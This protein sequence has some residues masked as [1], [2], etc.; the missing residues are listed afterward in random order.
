MLAKTQAL[1]L[2]LMI[3]GNTDIS[4]DP[5]YSR[6]TYPD[7]VLSSS[8]RLHNTMAPGDNEGHTNLHGLG[9]SMTLGTEPGHRL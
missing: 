7:M 3:S 4:T 8:P 5:G 9:G 2:S 1:A 6:T